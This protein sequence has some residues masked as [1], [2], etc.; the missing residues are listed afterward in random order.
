VL[1][2]HSPGPLQAHKRRGSKRSRSTPNKRL[3]CQDRKDLAQRRKFKPPTCQTLRR[4][5]CNAARR[6]GRLGAHHNAESLQSAVVYLH[7]HAQ[8]PAFL[9]I[10]LAFGRIRRRKGCASPGGTKCADAST[11]QAPAFLVILPVVGRIGRRNG[12][13]PAREQSVPTLRNPGVPTASIMLRASIPQE[14]AYAC[15]LQALAFLEILLAFDWIRRR[16]GCAPPREQLC[17]HFHTAGTCHS[18]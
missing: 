16:N 2:L 8:A 4:T 7:L 12:R 14:C 5:L 17:R 11:L 3:I 10:L 1:A 6:R 13:V 18:S 15:S 9:V